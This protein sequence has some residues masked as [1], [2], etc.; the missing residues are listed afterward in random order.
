MPRPKQPENAIQALRKQAAGG[1]AARVYGGIN[2][3]GTL[4]LARAAEPGRHPTQS[5]CMVPVQVQVQ[6]QARVLV[7]PGHIQAY[8]YTHLHCMSGVLLRGEQQQQQSGEGGVGGD[9]DATAEPK[10]PHGDMAKCGGGVRPKQAKQR[11]ATPPNGRSG[12]VDCELRMDAH[13]GVFVTGLREKR[14]GSK[15]IIRHICPS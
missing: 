14:S 10:R 13:F 3:G 4:G 2:D 15:Q 12:G 5:C 8:T 11:R 7:H 6:V 9:M 1:Q